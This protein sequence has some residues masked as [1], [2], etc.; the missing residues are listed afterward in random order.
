MSLFCMF[1]TERLTSLSIMQKIEKLSWLVK[2]S[3]FVGG[4]T[5]NKWLLVSKWFSFW[6]PLE[7]VH[8]STEIS[9]LCSFSIFLFFAD[10]VLIVF[11]LYYCSF[12]C[13]I[14]NYRNW[15]CAECYTMFMKIKIWLSAPPP[16]EKKI[17]REGWNSHIPN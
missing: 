17:L 9:R 7:I 15:Q 10:C 3:K 2:D 8:F 13:N 11:A 4:V 16:Q 12:I 6:K 5:L 1:F 14:C